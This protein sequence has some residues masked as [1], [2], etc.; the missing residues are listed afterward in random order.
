MDIE[1]LKA[2][3]TNLKSNNASPTCLKSLDI[4]NDELEFKYKERQEHIDML[5]KSLTASSRIGRWISSFKVVIKQFL[6]IKN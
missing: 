6:N 4:A 5:T 2:N 1:E 3:I